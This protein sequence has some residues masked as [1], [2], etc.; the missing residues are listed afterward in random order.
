MIANTV[1]FSV[2]RF[3]VMF[4][5]SNRGSLLGTYPGEMEMTGSRYGSNT[6]CSS[7]LEDPLP[8]M[9]RM[10]DDRPA[11]MRRSPDY[12]RPN[13]LEEDQDR[14]R[15]DH[16]AGSM[17]GRMPEG[18]GDVRKVVSIFDID[19]Q[20]RREDINN[21]GLMGGPGNRMGQERFDEDQMLAV[22][23]GQPLMRGSAEPRRGSWDDS[24]ASE[25]EQ[26][27]SYDHRMQTDRRMPPKNQPVP[28]LLDTMDRGN[29]EFGADRRKQRMPA[30]DS[31]MMRDQGPKHL[32]HDRPGSSM[33]DDFKQSTYYQN[34]PGNMA[35][36]RSSG[37]P[38]IAEH[39]SSYNRDDRDD[40][41]SER[42]DRFG[43]FESEEMQSTK[44]QS[45][46]PPHS[47]EQSD[48]VSLLLNLSQLLA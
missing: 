32:V 27:M 48:P 14:L 16:H 20:L 24:R 26:S 11:M 17:M 41:A 12:D 47:S 21:R 30:M 7:V 46:Q 6:L 36:G 13:Y 40:W 45:N 44:R 33:Q 8:K 5:T 22:Q 3:C 15:L 25:R 28:S 10:D 38:A 19:D 2:N 42:S 4:L 35:S 18:R 39:G 31:A 9:R 23:R 29:R 43:K 1:S 37:I 34:E